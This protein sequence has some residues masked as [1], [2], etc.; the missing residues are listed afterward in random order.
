MAVQRPFTWVLEVL[1]PRRRTR[2]KHTFRHLRHFAAVIAARFARLSTALE[3]PS[4][5]L[6]AN[7]RR[8]VLA[9][10]HTGRMFALR[11]ALLNGLLALDFIQ[12][13]QQVAKQTQVK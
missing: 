3:N 5:G 8:R 1:R 4:T 2:L 13:I 12:S 9:A 10:W 11:K 7:V 6:I